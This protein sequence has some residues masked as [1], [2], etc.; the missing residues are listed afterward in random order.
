MPE[1]LPGPQRR[2]GRSGQSRFTWFQ[3]VTLPVACRFQSR[4]NSWVD[5]REAQLFFGFTTTVI[6][7]KP[8]G[9]SRNDTPLAAQALSSLA[10]IGREALAKTSCPLQNWRKPAEVPVSLSSKRTWRLAPPFW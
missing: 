1:S 7:S 5:I 2:I 4:P 6:A 10:L 9:S 3:R 8:I